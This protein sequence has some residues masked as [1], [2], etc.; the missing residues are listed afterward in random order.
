MPCS[1]AR[2]FTGDCGAVS[3]LEKITEKKARA[4]DIS[5]PRLEMSCCVLYN[6][7]GKCVV[8]CITDKE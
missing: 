6:I 4:G 2:R 1:S 5:N 3:D 8:F 7:N